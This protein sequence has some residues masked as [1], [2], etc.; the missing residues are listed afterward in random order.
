MV[1]KG[2]RADGPPRRAGKV[3]KWTGLGIAGVFVVGLVASEINAAVNQGDDEPPVA[4]T[5]GE[6]QAQCDEAPG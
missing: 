5:T 1:G 2:D 4:R 6:V 3:L